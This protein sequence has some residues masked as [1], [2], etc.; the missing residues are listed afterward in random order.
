MRWCHVVIG[1][2]N[3]WLPGDPRGFRSRYHKVHSSGDYK[4]PPPEGEHA[5]LL[6]FSRAISSETVVIPMKLWPTVGHA[7]LE[8]FKKIGQ[9]AL[10][11]SVS[12]THCHCLV[13]LP[14]AIKEARHI[15][16]QCKAVS[17]HAIRDVLPGQVW[18]RGGSC[19]PVDSPQYQ[20]NVY[21]Y[22]LTQEN[23]WTWS[24]K[25]GEKWILAEPRRLEDSPA[26][27]DEKG[28]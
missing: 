16:G 1:T 3:S 21:H 19:K 28:T 12:A 23:A 9:Q 5:G 17:S 15:I 2:H 4:N 24:F 26:G 27:L 25:D 18:A 6:K 7:I 8:K 20:R 11:L 13:E 14:E 10:A 22:I